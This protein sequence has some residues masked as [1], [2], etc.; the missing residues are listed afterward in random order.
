MLD[1]V[2]ENGTVIDGSGRPGERF[3]IGVKYDKVV[4]TGDLGDVEAMRRIDASGLVVAPGFVDPHSHTDYTVH[5]N[6]TAQSTIRQGVTTEVVGN[7]GLTNA[8]VSAASR[9][10]VEDRL[11][12]Y[13]YKGQV[14]WSSFGEYLQD[15]EKDGTSQ[16]L[17]WLVGHSTVRAAAGVRG[18]GVTDD[19]LEVLAGYVEE[20]MEA[21]ALGISTGLEFREGRPA[22]AEEILRLAMVVGR[23]DG[24]YASHIRN[25]DARIH[26]AV[27]EFLN[28]VR[29]TSV[30]GQISHL[31]VRK[32]TGAP[33]HAWQDAVAL[34]DDARS[35]GLDV[36]A[37]MTPFR[38]GLGD[39]AG[40]LPPWLLEDGPAKAAARLESP[41]VRRRVRDD[42]DRYWRFI[43]KGQWHRV[44]L[45]HSEQFPE[46]DG[47]SFPEI[48]GARGRSEWDCF[49]DI[50]QAA[51]GHLEDLEM[52]GELF[53]DADLAEQLK[54][55]L[56]SCGAD[57]YSTSVAAESSVTAQTPLSFSGH[58]EYLSV[59]VR[60]RR[61]IPLEEMIRKLTSL[62]AT[63][64]GLR[65]RGR[66]AE[67]YFADLVVFDPVTVGSKATF[68]RPAVYPTGIPH[69][70]VNG[71]IVVDHGHH[72]GALP[73]QILRRRL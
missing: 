60:T 34:M 69:V 36:Q 25:R 29:L 2:I 40:I 32:D 65:G 58:T 71:Q 45:L 72:T 67:G 53:S 30:H 61:T 33:A 42:S 15:V 14:G 55:P 16:N 9:A 70:M 54:H 59:H 7:C 44:R 49:F 23:H 11:R 51:K 63:R 26:E 19:E 41:E 57:V 37:D 3:D 47:L 4:T 13:G 6:R 17:A 12:I 10:G 50:L 27:E 5:A 39:M 28:V 46:Y 38:E 66:I 20:A 52:V 64:F 18:E 56:F 31:N 62:P 8:P 22:S 24:F 35:R 73:G 21:G 68:A 43:H 48:A 1:V